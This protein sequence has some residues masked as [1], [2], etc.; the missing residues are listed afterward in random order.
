[1]QYDT[2]FTMDVNGE[3]QPWLVSD[4]QVS[5]DNLTY[6]LDLREDVKWHDGTDFTAEDVKFTFEYFTENTH[7]RFSKD[8]GGFE[9][10][11]VTGDYQVVITLSAVKPTYIVTAFADVPVLPKHIWEDIA[12]PAERDWEIDANIGTGP[13]NMVEYVPDQFYRFE[14]N[15]DYFAGK[16]TVG[17][18]VVVKLADT[19]GALSAFRTNEV[20]IVFPTVPPEQIELLG[21]V[22]GVKIAQGPQF[23]TQMV[24]FDTQ[25]P[26][27]DQLAVR[28]AIA[29]ALDRDDMVETV[30][31]GAATP[32]SIG[33]IHPGQT[34]FNDSVVTEYNPDEAKRLLDEAGIVDTD[35]DGV[36]EFDG[37]PMSFELVTPSANALRLRLAELAKQM[38]LE[39]GIEVEV[40]SVEQTTWEDA[41]W[42]EFDVAKGR[43]YEMAMWGW[44]APTLA[45]PSKVTWLIHSDPASG[46]LNLTG[47]ASEEADR[48][49]DALNASAD[50]EERAQL[51]KDIQVVIADE[52][53]FVMLMYPD[54]IYAYWATV[55]DNYAFIAGDGIVNKLSFLPEAARP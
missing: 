53:P 30:Y 40:A 51:I 46:F 44:S 15:V 12:D 9:S 28:K 34:V 38:L 35:G 8:I 50:P 27:F 48:L 32:G 14:A 10:A 43:N 49:S 17:E 47:F 45:E 29:L 39:V 11:E 13:Y 36:R 25:R 37:A 2:L 42:P 55:Y 3:P 22:E 41:V 52:I 19:A 18:L 1:M 20:D 6:T 23:S 16:P 21:A 26:P 24:N 33:W 31:L 4:Y 7:G 54:G 5:E